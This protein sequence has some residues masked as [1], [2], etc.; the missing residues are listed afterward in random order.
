MS[1]RLTRLRLNSAHPFKSFTRPY[2]LGIPS[3][4]TN[5]IIRILAIESSCDD[6]CAAIIDS[7]RTIH[8][9]IIISQA[10]VHAV[11]QGIHPYHAIN[12]HQLNIPIAIREAIKEAKIPLEEIDAIAYTRGPGIAGCL[13]VGA[14]AA[15]TLSVAFSKP[16][17]SVHHMQAHTLTPFLTESEPIRFPFLSLLVS[18]GHTLL[19]LVKSTFEFKILAQTVDESIGSTIDKVTRDL[20]GHSGGGPALEAFINEPNLD[21]SPSKPEPPLPVAQRTGPDTFSFCGLRTATVRRISDPISIDVKREIGKAFLEAAIAQLERKVRYWI[22]ELKSQDIQISGL[23][24]SGGVASNTMLRNRM[25]DMLKEVDPGLNFMV[26]PK[27]LCRDN[28]AMIGWTGLDKLSRGKI[29]KKPAEPDDL[30]TDEEPN[31]EEGDDGE[32]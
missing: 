30:Q 18:G 32:H 23:V 11:Y 15:K 6:S 20:L 21:P 27:E 4:K 2:T 22:Q 19:I 29:T 8:S 12:A 26:P 9:N 14:T 16:L 17:I 5:D 7:N 13:A 24:L 10:K 28:A 31:S 1:I 3:I 25:K